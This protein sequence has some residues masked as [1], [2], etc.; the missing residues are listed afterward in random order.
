MST[1]FSLVWL[2][3]SSQTAVEV[4]CN[5]LTRV[6]SE[7]KFAPRMVLRILS[8]V[9]Y[10]IFNDK[11]DSIRVLAAQVLKFCKTQH[12]KVGRLR[13]R[14]FLVKKGSVSQ[15]EQSKHK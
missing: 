11:N 3:L 9:Y 14:H 13:N 6:Q 8:G 12:L 1:R 5:V 2:F 15:L 4:P 10:K 7:K